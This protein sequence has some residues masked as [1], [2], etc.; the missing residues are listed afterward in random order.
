MGLQFAE[1]LEPSHK[2]TG[3]RLA[4]LASANC[5]SAFCVNEFLQFVVAIYLGASLWQVSCQCHE[6]SMACYLYEPCVRSS[7]ILNRPR[8]QQTSLWKLRAHKI[9]A[10]WGPEKCGCVSFPSR[11]S[12]HHYSLEINAWMVYEGSTYLFNF[13]I[14][15][16]LRLTSVCSS[17]SCCFIFNILFSP[18]C[19]T[20][21]TFRSLRTQCCWPT[22]MIFLYYYVGRPV[23]NFYSMYII[24]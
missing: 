12:Y 1:T 11:L 7:L 24:M 16:S 18:S 3:S 6:F 5:R 17:A 10:K 8:R 20:S 9:S 21:A 23:L 4:T 13:L 22:S 19:L 2:T 15:S 14:S